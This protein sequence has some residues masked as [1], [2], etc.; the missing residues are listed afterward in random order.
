MFQFTREFCRFHFASNWLDS[1]IHCIIA[2]T[3]ALILIW[4]FVSEFLCSIQIIHSPLY[5]RVQPRTS[6]R[7]ISNMCAVSVSCKVFRIGCSVHTNKMCQ[8]IQSV[9]IL[10]PYLKNRTNI[11]L[12]SY[13]YLYPCMS[14]YRIRNSLNVPY[15]ASMFWRSAK[16]ANTSLSTHVLLSPQCAEK[17]NKTNVKLEMQLLHHFH[18]KQKTHTLTWNVIKWEK[19]MLNC[20]NA[21]FETCFMCHCKWSEWSIEPAGHWELPVL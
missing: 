10:Y 2:A 1:C 3:L 6:N 12:T 9:V 5:S 21:S 7:K 16:N 18:R 15:C 19:F 11:A 8:F 4:I 20:T 17:W 14:S 13:F